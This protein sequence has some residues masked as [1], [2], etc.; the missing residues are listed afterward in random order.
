VA[1]DTIL[2]KYKVSDFFD[3]RLEREEKTREVRAYR[4]RPAYT[5]I[6]VRYQLH[7]TRKDDA[8]ETAKRRLGWRIYASNAKNERLTLSQAVLTYR[9]QYLVERDFARLHGHY[10]GITPLYVQ[11]D[12][13]ALGLIRLLTLALRAMV[14]M[15]FVVRELDIN[16]LPKKQKM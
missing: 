5:E 14:M 12:D 7:L 13:R 4:G 8:I 16:I 9:D 2:K 6:K 3:V 10:L 15:E 11:R 1:V